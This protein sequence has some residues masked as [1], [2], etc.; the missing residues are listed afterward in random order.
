[1]PAV[2]KAANQAIILHS[3]SDRKFDS[4]S[5]HRDP[6]ASLSDAEAAVITVPNDAAAAAAPGAQSPGISSN[7]II[8]LVTGLSGVAV[9]T[10]IGVMLWRAK[11]RHS[12]SMQRQK[13]RQHDEM[14]RGP[15]DHQ[16]GVVRVGCGQH[17]DNG[18]Y[19]SGAGDVRC[20]DGVR[21]DT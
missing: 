16:G 10:A 19:H 18:G 6:N 7:F 3:L 4:T 9:V 2:Q 8:G 12:S 14:L 15:E 17:S 21:A 11:A 13:Q 5:G 20:I 1:M